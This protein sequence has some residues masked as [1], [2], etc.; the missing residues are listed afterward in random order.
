MFNG[1]WRFPGMGS[2]LSPTVIYRWLLQESKCPC[3]LLFGVSF[4]SQL[5]HSPCQHLLFTCIWSSGSV[6]PT[7]LWPLWIQSESHGANVR[8][9]SG[10][11]LSQILLRKCQEKE[12][13]RRSGRFISY[14][15]V[16]DTVFISGNSTLTS[17][18]SIAS[19]HPAWVW[20]R[21][22]QWRK[23]LNII[24]SWA[25]K[26][27]LSLPSLTVPCSKVANYF[28]IQK[29]K[30]RI[31]VIKVVMKTLSRC[32]VLVCMGIVLRR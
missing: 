12:R 5:N 11:K 29:K 19:L 32:R 3:T 13:R 17:V 10:I 16:C 21:K 14:L 20:S 28:P 8:P 9:A 4:G 26:T 30:L 31:E 23:E 6:S 18:P 1:L 25:C 24:H 22:R 7:P 27:T 2:R 15:L